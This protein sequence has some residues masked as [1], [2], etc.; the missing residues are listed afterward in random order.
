MI[1]YFILLTSKKDNGRGNK[2]LKYVNNLFLL[3][4]ALIKAI[5]F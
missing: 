3:E 2:C 1:Q 5:T 4:S